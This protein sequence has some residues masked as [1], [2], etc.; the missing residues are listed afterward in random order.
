MASSS[1]TEKPVVPAAVEPSSLGLTLGQTAANAV[2]LDPASVT[3]QPSSDDAE[4]AYIA[5]AV[6]EIDAEADADEVSREYL[7]NDKGK[8]KEMAPGQGSLKNQNKHKKRRDRK[9]KDQS[10]KPAVDRATIS[11]FH[12]VDV[13]YGRKTL[14]K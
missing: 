12:I 14:I 10:E 6:A 4:M 13:S 7:S 5:N 3:S 1:I 2:S 8:G 11:E 9:R